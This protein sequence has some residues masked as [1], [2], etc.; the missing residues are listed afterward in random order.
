[1]YGARYTFSFDIEDSDVKLTAPSELKEIQHLLNKK[2]DAGKLLLEL[3]SCG[4]CL[5]PQDND[6]HSLKVHAALTVKHHDIEKE[7]SAS[8]SRIAP[9]H[10]LFNELQNQSEGNTKCI[11]KVQ[12]VDL[13]DLSA[14]SES[15]V[16]LVYEIDA[17]SPL[18]LKCYQGQFNGTTFSV[19][20]HTLYL[21]LIDFI[22]SFSFAY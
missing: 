7:M 14:P 1:L 9:C 8:L 12:D 10:M 2:M 6:A 11:V 22:N 17:G 4:I 16:T 20:F 15:T 19:T 21:C 3:A 18:G 13:T 5:L